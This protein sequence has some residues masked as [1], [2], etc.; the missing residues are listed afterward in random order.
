MEWRDYVASVTSYRNPT[1][2]RQRCIIRS[3]SIDSSCLLTGNDSE[4]AGSYPSVQ[5]GRGLSGR[6][7]EYS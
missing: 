1:E 7:H 5:E 2:H 3:G 6:I 4:Q